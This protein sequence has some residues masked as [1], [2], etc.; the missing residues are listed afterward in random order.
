LNFSSSAGSY[1]FHNGPSENGEEN[2]YFLVA[3]DNEGDRFLLK[4]AMQENHIQEDFRFVNGGVE[5]IE[6][7]EQ[8]K[9]TL[10]APGIPL[11]SLILLD[12]YM[13]RMDG[14][15]ALRAIKGDVTLKKIPTIILTSSHNLNDVVQSYHDGANSFLT[16]PLEY[17]RLVSLVGL[18]KH[19]WLQESKLPV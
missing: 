17:D 19:Y 6:F 14:Y 5:L 4:K 13:P 10:W 1:P 12:L 15:Q 2:K 7:L 9:P 16:K 3:D 8:C 11:P 18:V